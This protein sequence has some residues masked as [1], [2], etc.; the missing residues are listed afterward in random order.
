MIVQP[1][2]KYLTKDE[3]SRLLVRIDNRR[4]KLLIQLGLSLG[5]RVSEVVN[6]KLKHIVSDR[7]RIWDEK[8]DEYRDCVIDAGTRKLLDDYLGNDWTAKKHFRH[9]VFYFSTKTANRIFKKWCSETKLPGEKAHFHTLRHTYIIQSLDAGVPINHIVE[10]TGNTISTIMQHY[11]TPSI[12]SRKDMM[13]D[14]GVY[15]A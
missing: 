1:G 13:Q 3:I 5:C 8:K 11:G 10:Q 4:D 12:D 6:I 9:Q 14:R 2:D 7:I 15:W